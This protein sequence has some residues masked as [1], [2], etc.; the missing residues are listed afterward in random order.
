MVAVKS[1][2]TINT[3][4]VVTPTVYRKNERCRVCNFW[5]DKIMHG[6]YLRDLDGKDNVKSWKWLKDSDLKG[7][8]EALICSAQEQAIRKIIL[9]LI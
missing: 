5:K 4:N 1:N 9:S 6:Q 3:E 2:K 8:T 7:C